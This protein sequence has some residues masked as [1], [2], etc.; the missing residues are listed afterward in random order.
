MP[1]RRFAEPFDDPDWIF[2]LKYDGFRALAYLSE[3]RCRL[4][5]RNGNKFKSFTSLS[6]ELSNTTRTAAVLDGEVS[7]PTG[8]YSSI[9]FS[10]AEPGPCSWRSTFSRVDTRTCAISRSWIASRN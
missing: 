10:I 1:L 7:T 2:E 6:E 9:T 4:V 5:S 8:N 3:G